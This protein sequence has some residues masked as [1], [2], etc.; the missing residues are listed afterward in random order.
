VC[1]CWCC[2]CAQQQQQQEDAQVIERGDTAILHW[3]L[4]NR[5]F[6]HS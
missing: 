1:H 2:G 3:L 6:L 5:T 4:H